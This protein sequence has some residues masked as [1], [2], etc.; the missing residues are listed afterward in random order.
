MANLKSTIESLASQF[1]QNL[2]RALRGVSIEELVAL[3]SGGA[4]GAAGPAA[5][6][7]AA[8]LG[9][10][11]GKGGRLPRRSVEEI[12]RMVDSIAD[13][14]A[15]SPDGLRA[16]QIRDALGVDAKELPR[17]L[18]DGVKSGRFKKTGQKR[19]TTYFL[20]SGERGAKRRAG[21]RARRNK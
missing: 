11:R 19:A 9:R 10:R 21:G 16:E 17:P 5:A 12:G 15:K 8:Q 13:L 14:L 20:G 4:R 2:I 7:G 1:A 18:A 3:S 6:R